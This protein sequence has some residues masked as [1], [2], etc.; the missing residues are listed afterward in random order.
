MGAQPVGWGGVEVILGDSKGQQGL[1]KE[2]EETGGD[3]ATGE[4]TGKLGEG[5]G[6]SDRN[7]FSLDIFLYY[8]SFVPSAC[9]TQPTK[10]EIRE[11][12][13]LGIWVRQSQKQKGPEGERTSRVG[14][15][16]GS[17]PC[18]HR[19]RPPGPNQKSLSMNSCTAHL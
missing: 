5:R 3:G 15:L 10:N 6:S 14:Y 18:S 4:E 7:H 19:P 11:R 9:M 8:L 1:C 16:A 13:I 17:L 2:T 12:G